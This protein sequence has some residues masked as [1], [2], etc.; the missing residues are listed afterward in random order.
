MK[1]S[2][3][4]KPKI[5]PESPTVQK[6]EPINKSSRA[7]KVKA[8]VL[9]PKL[10]PDHGAVAVERASSLDSRDVSENHSWNGSVEQDVKPDV[11]ELESLLGGL[12]LVD[13]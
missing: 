4:I 5:E 10:E 2:E 6:P 3:E 7:R 12:D 1:V 13:Q 8:V 9:Q 11:R